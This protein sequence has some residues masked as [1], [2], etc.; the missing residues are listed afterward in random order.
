MT[1][2]SSAS[3]RYLL[4][5]ARLG[6]LAAAGASAALLIQYLNPAAGFCAQGGGCDA[7]KA[8]SVGWFG[9]TWLNLPLL[10]L[11]GYTSLFLVSAS[12][13]L[14]HRLERWWTAAA[15]AGA[16]A[17]LAFVL[18]QAWVVK[19]FC[20]LCL[21][22]DA[23]AVIVGLAGLLASR[24]GFPLFRPL[25]PWA[26]IAHLALVVATPFV[27]SSIQGTTEIPA[28]VKELYVPGK[29]NIIEFADAQCPHCRRLH[30]TLKT[31]V[32]EFREQV[33][34]V[35]VHKPLGGHALAGKAAY[36]VHCARLQG[37]GTQMAD[38]VFEQRL[39]SDVFKQHAESLGLNA[40]AFET[41]STS[42]DTHASVAKEA[43]RLP[44]EAFAG[45]PT[46]FIQDQR[47]LGN[48]GAALYRDVIHSKLANR[49]HLSRTL[50]F[51]IAAVLFAAIGWIGQIGQSRSKAIP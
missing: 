38:L 9:S 41:C 51:V 29:V 40:A 44:K 37:R 47:I 3:D 1:A 7:V 19:A 33:N 32:H 50:W 18:V 28:G 20:S 42:A 48:R 21:V 25:A 22:V 31:V 49:S 4:T 16:I 23:S 6:C 34:F 30:G 10:G 2:T 24:A 17:A 14:L 45:L 27:A 36:A 46:T 26:R 35:Q 39:A 8:A 43:A 13:T 5:L 12:D 15:V 11:V